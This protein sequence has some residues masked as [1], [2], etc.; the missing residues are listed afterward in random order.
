MIE[1]LN[2][3]FYE[4]P[5]QMKIEIAFLFSA[6]YILWLVFISWGI[7]KSVAVMMLL[8]SVC[9]FSHVGFVHIKD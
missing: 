2:T 1:V 9:L 6:I 3:V 7:V 8:I 4:I 5:V